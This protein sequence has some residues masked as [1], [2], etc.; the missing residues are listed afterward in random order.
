[1]DGVK[2]WP[3][4]LRDYRALL[5]YQEVHKYNRH[6]EEKGEHE[7]E[8][9]LW[10]WIQRISCF[11]ITGVDATYERSIVLK[12]PHHHNGHFD[13]GQPKCTKRFLQYN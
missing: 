1:M 2:T 7:D 8:C 4:L 3:A 5:S 11:V 6:Q 10:K 9:Y 12:L 13:D